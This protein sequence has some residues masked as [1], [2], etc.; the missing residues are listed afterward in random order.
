[1]T[2]A[3]VLR[4]TKPFDPTKTNISSCHL[5]LRSPRYTVPRVKMVN[6]VKVKVDLSAS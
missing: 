3:K 2:R 5:V 6:V 1:M 4:K